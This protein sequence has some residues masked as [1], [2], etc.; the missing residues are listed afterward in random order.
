MTR[1]ILLVLVVIL[2][3]SATAYAQDA[4]CHDESID[5]EAVEAQRQRELEA[6]KSAVLPVFAERLSERVDAVVDALLVSQGRSRERL[7]FA[8][9]RGKVQ[10]CLGTRQPDTFCAAL[11]R[12]DESLCAFTVPRDDV[13]DPLVCRMLVRMRKAFSARNP[14]L[15][16]GAVGF[17]SLC[18]MVIKGKYD[19]TEL[20]GDEV[21]H[22]ACRHLADP[23]RC[24]LMGTGSE[25]ICSLTNFVSALAGDAG[26]CARI[27]AR[28]ASSLGGACR[29]VVADDDEQLCPPAEPSQPALAACRAAQAWTP[30][31]VRDGL[32]LR[33]TTAAAN[34]FSVPATCELRATA[35]TETGAALPLKPVQVG[36]L[37]PRQVR[38]V[39]ESFVLPAGT[40]DASARVACTWQPSL[41]GQRIVLLDWDIH[42]KDRPAIMDPGAGS[43]PP[44]SAE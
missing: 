13:V 33:V 17:D 19:C 16:K 2:A 9:V 34:V 31:L 21:L 11:V 38:W 20:E 27:G 37:G 30:E 6:R 7:A 35:R 24:R 22:L 3:G 44:A 23:G 25:R 4:A 1:Q 5:R 39:E 41:E 40:Q 43:P 15:C 28:A 26:A 36:T 14:S 29:A 8:A 18:R 10:R 12:R 32:R 42:E